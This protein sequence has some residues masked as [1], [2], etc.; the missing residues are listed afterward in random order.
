MFS[1]I[2]FIFLIRLESDGGATET[3]Y[4]ITFRIANAGFDVEGSL[5]VNEG[6]IDFDADNL[7]GSRVRVSADPSS[8]Q[9]G[10]A[11][12]DN[13]LKRSDYLDATKYPLILLESKEF[14]KT[15]KNSF[16]G[17]FNLTIKSVTREVFIHFTRKKN[18]G[19]THYSGAFEVN[20]LD[21]YIGEE[22]LTLDNTIRVSVSAVGNF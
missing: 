8:I 4:Q 7:P 11:I 18:G 19:T 16:T 13:H 3:E 22:S 1:L 20:R 6:K 9:T 15:G 2:L 5:K 12:R 10:I 21:F 14:V 17:K